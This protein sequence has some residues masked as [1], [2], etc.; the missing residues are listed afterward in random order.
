MTIQNKHLAILKKIAELYP[1]AITKLAIRWFIFNEKNN[2]FSTC[3]MWF[4]RKILIETNTFG[5]WFRAQ[6]GGVK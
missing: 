2:G 1:S 5:Y 3:S 6:K 4:C